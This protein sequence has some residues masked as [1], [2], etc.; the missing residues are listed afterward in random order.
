MSDEVERFISNPTLM[1]LLVVGMLKRLRNEKQKFIFT[2]CIL[3]GRPQ[4]VAAEILNIHE[5]NVARE[6]RRI[7]E[8][9]VPYAKGYDI[10]AKY[11]KNATI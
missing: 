2:F 7:R 6:I 3:D 4:K 10:G 9:L 1:D 11:V 5:T 8:C